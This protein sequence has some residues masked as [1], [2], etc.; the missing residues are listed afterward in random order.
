M[1]GKLIRL[2]QRKRSAKLATAKRVALALAIATSTA[3]GVSAQRPNQPQLKHVKVPASVAE[4]VATRLSLQYLDQPGVTITPDDRPGGGLLVLAPP[5]LQNKIAADAS[6]L[7]SSLAQ[8]AGSQVA[9]PI[10]VHLVNITWREVED[11][12]RIIAGEDVP[13]T[14]SRNGERASFTLTME[15]RGGSTTRVE[16]DRRSNAVTLTTSPMMHNTWR[17]TIQA[18]DQAP[19]FAGEETRVFMLQYAKIASVQRAIRL[20]RDLDPKSGSGTSARPASNRTQPN[21]RTAAF[22]NDGGTAPDGAADVAPADDD[23]D[24]E[25]PAGP[26]GDPEIQ[27]VPESGLIIVKGNKRDIQRVMDI[28]KDIEEKSKLTQPEIEV[29]QLQHADSNAVAAL[30]TQ[31]YEDVLSARQGDVSI[32]ALDSPNALLLIGRKEAIEAVNNLIEKIDQPIPDTDRLRVFRLQHASATDA[33]ATIQTFFTNQPGG[34]EENRPGLGVRVRISADYRTNSL[35]VSASPRDLAEVTRLVE[36][37]DVQKIPST[38]EIKVFPLTNARAE[39]MVEVLQDSISGEPENIAGDTTNAATSL[40][41]VSL[42]SPGNPILDSGILSGAVIT[43]DSNVNAVV[44]RAPA[45][46]MPLIGE[47]IRQL[48]QTPGIDSLVK[49][50]TIENGDATQ[51]TTALQNLFG[52]DAATNGTSVGAGNLGDLPSLSAS[53]SALTPLVFS[54]DIRTNSIIASGSA[55]DLE[56]VESI[57]L[58]LDSE[59]FA[60]RITEVIWLKHQIAQNVADAITAY[61][62][63][64]AQSRNNIQQFQQ[65]LGPLD[66]PDRDIVA[67]AEGQTNSVLLSVSPRIYEEVRQLIDRLD[68]R[69]PMV[70]IKTLIAE[71]QLDDGFEIGGEFGLQDSLLFDRGVATGT[72]SDPG[73]NFNGTSVNLPNNNL[74]GQENLAAQGLTNFGAGASQLTQLSG[75]NS[76]GFVFSAASESVNLFLRT[77]RVANRLQILSRPEIMTADNTTGFVQ[78]GQSF[79]RPTELSFTGGTGGTASQ[80]IIG[81]EDEE[82]GII[83]RV[84]P[85]VGAD[86][87]IFMDIDASRSDINNNEG[88]II[89]AFQ[90]D[91][92]IFVPAIDRTQAQ[93]SLTAFDGQTVVFGGL[94]QKVRQNRTRRVPY[95]SNIPLLGTFFKFDSEIEQRSELLVVMTPILVT[96][97]EDLEYVKQVE[98]SRMSWCLADVVEMHGDVGLSGGYGLWGPAVGPTIYPD[99]HPTVDVFPAADMPGGGRAMKG[100]MVPPGTVINSVDGHVVPGSTN[101]LPSDVK[102]NPG[103]SIIHNDWIEAPQGSMPTPQQGLPVDQLPAPVTSTPGE[104]LPAPAS[105]GVPVTGAGFTGTKQAGP[106]TSPSGTKVQ[107]KQVSAR[108]PAKPAVETPAAEKPVGEDAPA[109][110]RWFNFNRSK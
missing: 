110:K 103:E 62:S 26:I 22:Q 84:T 105:S 97:Q 29:R 7:S 109:K 41:I 37:I 83:L 45:G 4:S 102:L 47:L 15:K 10:T 18:I 69:P 56:V 16:V 25:D 2:N 86:G 72:V 12:L 67:V 107:A 6:T 85:R 88:Q 68:R 106:T 63:Q 91:V 79:P 57:L 99:I 21:F 64:R 31:L 17:K 96:G 52:E 90:D 75:L 39:D 33:E 49:V 66:L 35:I 30:L 55:E 24:G 101:Q 92:P 44:V 87:L 98:S 104:F 40:S 20:L 36:E 38:A 100:G 78:V 80:P 48:D 14:T 65:G 53:E 50:F 70:L 71:V 54:T 11:A 46:G 60:E 94:I 27:F 89:G 93:A 58:R 81:I 51:L 43:A 5:N 28:V 59:G 108:T 34:D 95:L 23:V 74:V 13:V 42:N 9:T 77:L 61:V 76:G 1:T 19:R 32:T 73:F 82:I 8:V 3:M